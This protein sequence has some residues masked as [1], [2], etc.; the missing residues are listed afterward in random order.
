MFL[1]PP[2]YSCA[3]SLR[4][5]LWTRSRFG[6]SRGLRRSRPRNP[7]SPRNLRPRH[8]R[9][10]V[11]RLADP[12]LTARRRLAASAAARRARYGICVRECSPVSL[13]RSATHR[14]R[15][16]GSWYAWRRTVRRMA[17][18]PARRR[19]C[20]GGLPRCLR[21]QLPPLHG[22]WR[23]RQ[24]RSVPSGRHRPLIT[25]TRMHARSSLRRPHAPPR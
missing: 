23:R 22:L 8:C 1:P 17:R 6:L 21:S 14:C 11:A 9:R 2:Y 18:L 20:A 3:T 15:D 16:A 10:G 12:A 13:S 7:H 4:K 5:C 19:R 24:P 25:M